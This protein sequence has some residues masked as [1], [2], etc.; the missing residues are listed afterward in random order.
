AR[1]GGEAAG[2][3]RKAVEARTGGTVI[4]SKNAAQ[5][6]A[7]VTNMIEASASADDAESEEDK[8]E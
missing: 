6:N 2:E 3:A 1:S 7:A 5:L 8:D 4:T